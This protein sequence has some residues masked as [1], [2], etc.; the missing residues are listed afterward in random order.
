[1]SD[2]D[3]NK[4]P[5]DR[6]E[7]LKLIELVHTRLVGNSSQMRAW[8]VSMVTAAFIFLGLSDDPHWIIPAGGGVAVIA[9]C[10]IDMSYVYLQKGFIKLFRAAAD[11]ETKRPFEMNHKLHRGD[12][13]KIVS[14]FFTWSIAPF[15]TIILIVMLG[16]SLATYWDVFGSPT[17]APGQ[18]A[19]FS[20]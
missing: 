15:Y 10:M 5:Q 8:T 18:C 1:M 3:E 9:F 6:I 7:H 13:S 2:T 12:K 20:C 4:T 11:G 16:L 17:V 14:I 19:W